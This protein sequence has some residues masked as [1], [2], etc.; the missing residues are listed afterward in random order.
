MRSILFTVL[1]CAG[2]SVAMS[3]SRT[4]VFGGIDISN[5][6]YI[7]NGEKQDRSSVIGM[8]FGITRDIDLGKWISLQ[9]S[10]F[11]IRKGEQNYDFEDI[12]EI[13]SK[14]TFDYAGISMPITFHIVPGD[15]FRIYAGAG[16]YLAYAVSGHY[17]LYRLEDNMK[18][19][20]QIGNG[21]DDDFKPMDVG[22][23]IVAGTDIKAG[24]VGLRGFIQWD[25]GLTNINPSRYPGTV[26]TK[27]FS[28]GLGII[29]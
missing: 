27:S 21:D 1:L 10:V 26:K 28:V 2:A 16:P 15:E 23:S 9:P 6:K 12:D 13:K 11:Y 8:H 19:K 22:Y 24:K 20:L 5:V 25:G 14:T 29:F 18:T 17:T 4:I 3:Q 7:L